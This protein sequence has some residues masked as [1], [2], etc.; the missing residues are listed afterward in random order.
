MANLSNIRFGDSTSDVMNPANYYSKTDTD[1]LLDDK[2][3]TTDVPVITMQ[4]ADPGEGQP[5]AANHFIAVYE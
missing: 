2:A 4:T 1:A 5:L 3:D